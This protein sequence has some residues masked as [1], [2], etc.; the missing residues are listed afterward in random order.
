MDFFGTRLY[1][2]QTL[3]SYKKWLDTEQKQ[4]TNRDMVIDTLH[5]VAICITLIVSFN[6]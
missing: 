3:H 4:Y 5:W 6:N 1:F 2:E